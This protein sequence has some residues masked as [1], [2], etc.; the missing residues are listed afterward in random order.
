MAEIKKSGKKI[1]FTNGCFDILHVG[2]VRYLAAARSE[3][4]VL[5]VGLNSDESVK[6]IKSTKR[7]IVKQDERAEV[8][9]SLWCVDYIVLFNQPD[10]LILIQ[11]ISHDILVKGDDWTEENI[12]GADFVK[13][14]GGRVVRVQVVPEASTSKII[15]RIVKRYR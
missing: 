6:S 4:D 3:G 14:K 8:L 13:K 5:V 15:E 11:T 9:A 12:I 7:P 10:P 1:V 2:H